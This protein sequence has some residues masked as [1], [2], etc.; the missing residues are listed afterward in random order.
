MKPVTI[1]GERAL[2]NRHLEW[3]AQQD[4]VDEFFSEVKELLFQLKRANDHTPDKP[5][6]RCPVIADDEPCRGSVWVHDEIQPVWRR[7]PDRCSQ[8][9]E[10]APG[11]AVCDTCGSVW[12]TDG[13]KARLKRMVE[14]QAAEDARPRTEDGRRMLTA[15]ELVELGLV[16]SV[17]NVRQIASRN[18]V[19]PV[20]G[21]YDPNLFARPGPSVTAC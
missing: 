3:I 16:S 5:H 21:H 8:T 4:W 10:K 2:L 15:Q 7:Y 1:S 12:A 20:H 9:W 11:S 6:C 17:G 18:S 19:S 13:E 14:Y